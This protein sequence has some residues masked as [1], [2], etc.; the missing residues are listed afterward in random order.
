MEVTITIPPAQVDR[1]KAFVRS[2]IDVGTDPETGE[3]NP[4]PTNAE[5][6]L[7]FK[8]FLRRYI[9]AEVQQ[10]ELL[11][12]HELSFQNYTPVEPE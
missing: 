3:P 9:K 5:L 6:L 7:E 12:E 8:H 4:E 1:L 11:K 2:K 10:F